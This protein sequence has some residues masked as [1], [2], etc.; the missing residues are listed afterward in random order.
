MGVP[1]A[2]LGVHVGGK[3]GVGPAVRLGVGEYRGVSVINGVSVGCCVH[4]GAAVQVGGVVGVGDGK[5]S[6]ATGLGSGFG[7]NG[8]RD[9]TKS[10][11]KHIRATIAVSTRVAIVNLFS[12]LSRASA[13]SFVDIAHTNQS[14][15]AY[16]RTMGWVPIYTRHPT[17]L[18]P[19][20][21]QLHP[22]ELYSSPRRSRRSD[23]LG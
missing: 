12:C 23:K 9:G 22:T 11:S 10:S 5:T 18:N 13:D 7:P 20:H 21:W 1:G 19:G 16:E 6:I 2:D 8:D 15:L 17:T 14:V 4:V 3:V